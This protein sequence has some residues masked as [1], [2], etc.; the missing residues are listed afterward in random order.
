[1]HFLFGAGGTGGHLYPAIA[2]AEALREV[3]P[4][5]KITFTGRKDK[6]EGTKVAEFG[7]DFLPVD[8]EGFI[9]KPTISA[10]KSAIKLLI[11]RNQIVKFLNINKCDA[12]IVAGAYISIPP[13]FAAVKSKI[14]LFLMESNVN[15]GKAISL[16]TAKSKLVFTSF[17]ESDNYFPQKFRDKIIFT[18]NPVRAG[19]EKLLPVNIAKKELGF[20][21]DKAL[22]LIFGGS[23]GAASINKFV[24]ENAD[25]F[26]N[27]NINVAWQTGNLY[28]EP[29]NLPPN[30]KA[31]KFIDNMSLFYSAAD[32]I[33][34]RSGASTVSELTLTGKPSVLIPLPS[35]SNNEQLK[36]AEILSANNAAVL[37]KDREIHSNLFNIVNNLIFDV[38]KMKLMSNNAKKLCK[39]GAAEIIAKNIL[40]KTGY[41]GKQR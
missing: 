12:V 7:F 9:I 16:L 36:N 10:A 26:Y 33:I 22:L 21:D 40:E 23:L 1:M 13:G 29:Q 31:F 25:N 8:I 27:S 6:I 15:P 38:E 4:E 2:V 37:V 14:P 39:A 19:F 30:I 35:A 11:A 24:A 28:D 5:F 34:S 17:K 3:N 18:G 20:D 32:L 41:Y